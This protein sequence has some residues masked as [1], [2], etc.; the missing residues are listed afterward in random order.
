V[1][2]WVL[3]AVVGAALI[4]AGALI[5]KNRAQVSR[6][7]QSHRSE[8]AKANNSPGNMALIGCLCVV[9]GVVWAV[10]GVVGAINS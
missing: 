1:I 3:M 4:G 5:V 10:Y 7:Q 8:R 6:W 9:I 2:G